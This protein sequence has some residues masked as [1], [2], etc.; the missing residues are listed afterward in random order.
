[1]AVTP[2]GAVNQI[3]AKAGCNA[4]DVAKPQSAI[5]QEGLEKGSFEKTIRS[6]L[7]SANAPQ[8]EANLAVNDLVAGRTDS[9]HSVVVSVAKAEMSFRFLIEMRNRLTEAYQEIMRMQM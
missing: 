3:A 7:E 8:K 6:L 2:M 1:M 5:K 4:C 9:I